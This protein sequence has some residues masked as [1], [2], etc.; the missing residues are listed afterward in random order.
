MSSKTYEQKVA[1]LVQEACGVKYTK[2]LD[3]VRDHEKRFPT[4]L[5]VEE[6]AFLIMKETPDECDCMDCSINE[7]E[8]H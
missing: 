7:E 2:A 8:T 1:R 5:P 4:K 3:L 6:R